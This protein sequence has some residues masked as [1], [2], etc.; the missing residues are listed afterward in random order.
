MFITKDHRESSLN[1][2]GV[3]V[4]ITVTVKSSNIVW[5]HTAEAIQNV[6]ATVPL[7]HQKLQ[8]KQFSSNF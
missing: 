7:L 3:Q 4:G 5:I 1:T 2:D 8:K 6:V